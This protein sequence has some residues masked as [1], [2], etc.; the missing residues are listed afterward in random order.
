VGCADRELLMAV[1]H[2]DG[3]KKLHS[4][5]TRMLSLLAAGPDGKTAQAIGRACVC[6]GCGERCQD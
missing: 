1:G 3:A 5:T 2:V 4:A 6:W